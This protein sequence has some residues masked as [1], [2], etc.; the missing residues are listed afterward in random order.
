MNKIFVAAV[1]CAACE[2]N[3]QGLSGFSI[4]GFVGTEAR[5]KT[6]CENGSSFDKYRVGHL[7]GMYGRFGRAFNNNFYLGV[8]LYTFLTTKNN[9]E[10][11]DSST[12]VRYKRGAVF[13]IT[14]VIGHVFGTDTM[15]YAKLG[16]ETSNDKAE[17]ILKSANLNSASYVS[18]TT[19]AFAPG[20]GFEHKFNNHFVAGIDY[21]YS[22]GEKLK[23]IQ[24]KVQRRSHQV[25][26]RFGYKF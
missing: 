1:A 24:S 18:K 6:Y 17:I 4:G 5:T 19:Y 25:M 16:I 20:F 11:V 9:F 3:A 26:F 10:D 21:T 2:L 13:G 15:A 12:K 7:F 23:F 14:P 8:E 22:I